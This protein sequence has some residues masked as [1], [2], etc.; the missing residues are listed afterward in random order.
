MII[1]FAQDH[2]G[3]KRGDKK[4]FHANVASGFVLQGFA[5]SGW[6]DL[7]EEEAAVIEEESASE[8][9]GMNVKELK[10]LAK[11]RGIENSSTMK[12][13]ELVDALK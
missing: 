13:Q 2:E 5:V 9:D 3:Y 8:F 10:E 7:P 12:R 1:T 6:I 11:E 4:E